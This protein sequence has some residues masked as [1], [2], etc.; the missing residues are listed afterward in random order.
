[1]GHQFE[2]SNSSSAWERV[3]EL[4]KAVLDLGQ[5]ATEAFYECL[6]RRGIEPTL[7][8]AGELFVSNPVL[9]PGHIVDWMTADLNRFVDDRRDA[10]R[11]AADLLAMLPVEVRDDFASADVAAVLCERLQVE[12][13]LASLDAFLV[14]T[15]D[16]LMPTYVEW[17]TVGTYSTMARWILACAQSAWPPLAAASPT[18]TRGWD[19]AALDARLAALYLSG[20]EDDPRQ[21]V[22]LDYKP[23]EQKSRREFFAIQE[24]T[25]GP[26]GGW[27]LLDPRE[28]VYMTT[29]QAG[30]AR[31]Y[32]HRDG[33]LVPIRRAYSRLV[34]SDIVGR[35]WPDCTPEE[36]KTIRRLFGDP[37][38]D[39]LGHPIHFY[40]GTK[41]D[42]VEFY[43]AGRSPRVPETRLVTDDLLAELQRAGRDP[44]DGLV[45]KP[46][47]GNSGQA[48][49]LNPPLAQVERGGLL[50]ARIHP[51]ACHPTL[52]GPRVPEIR[53]MGIPDGNRLVGAALYN[54]VMPPDSFK[55]NASAVAVRGV[56]GTGEGF[57]FV[58]W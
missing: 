22:I 7:R 4:Y 21:G 36:R 31:P 39:W 1:M 6:R 58:V 37:N 15:P 56:P 12:P 25:G 34:H 50:Q 29:G 55:S 43:R 41:A 33:A 32:Y 38:V 26:T 14:D 30:S 57:G 3:D 27:G 2:I 19:M 13:P 8:M 47:L 45:Y 10:V 53:L 46:A 9:V 28:V 35:F 44:L 16:G 23:L 54:R 17:Q 11:D 20:V 49:E 40:Y 42:F 52:F 48:V 51:A 18:A 5:A 24:L